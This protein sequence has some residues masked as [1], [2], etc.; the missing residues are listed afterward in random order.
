MVTELNGWMLRAEKTSARPADRE[1]ETGVEGDR[2]F[3]EDTEMF[4]PPAWL[5]VGRRSRGA[6]PSRP[7]SAEDEAVEYDL[8]S[9]DGWV[10]DNSFVTPPPGSRS[11]NEADALRRAEFEDAE[12]FT[13]E[14]TGAQKDFGPQLR[15]AWHE[16][17]KATFK[18]HL[19]Q[20]IQKIVNGL[21]RQPPRR[22]I[23]GSSA[24]RRS[25]RQITLSEGNVR[26]RAFPIR[27]G[28]PS[29]ATYRLVDEPAL[30]GGQMRIQDEYCE[31]RVFRGKATKNILRVVFTSEPPEYYRFLYDPG[32]PRLTKSARQLLV[33]L[34]QRRC[35]TTA[36][37]LTDLERTV[38]SVKVYDTGNKWNNEHCVHLQ[39]P[40]NTLGAQINIA[41]RAAVLRSRAGSLIT[42][43]KTLIACDGFGDPDRQSDPAIGDSVNKL[44]RENRF[45]TLENP[46]GLYM[47]SLDTS[48]WSTPD[49]TDAQKFWKV[50]GGRMDKD[51]GKSMIVRAE[52]TVPASK[53]YTV[54]DIKIAGVPIAFGSQIAEHLEM[55]LG[56]R[57]GPKDTDLQ[58]GKL[59]APTPVVC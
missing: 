26:W 6:T 42:D 23:C 24:P 41:A 38:G 30:R 50:L 15:N 13:F 36:V 59:S 28:P 51:Q 49:G 57:V 31:W 54:S 25:R 55:R 19:D 32:V 33:R 52:F 58:G 53:G 21:G 44:A 43:V 5:K 48:G 35:G 12:A 11:S 1:A 20:G 2:H 10:A 14:P 46:V 40:E 27:Y 18:L 3:A 47:T 39:Q 16:L 45:L 34:Y 22:S 37:R 4:T 29:T 7:Q 9:E 8:D 17:I 56:A